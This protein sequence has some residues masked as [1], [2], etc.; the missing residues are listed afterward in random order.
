MTSPQPAYDASLTR[1]AVEDLT[2][3]YD[4]QQ[5]RVISVREYAIRRLRGERFPTQTLWPLRGVSFD[6][7]AGESFGIVGRNGAGKSTL[8]KVIAGIV[9]PT[10]GRVRVHGHLSPL[11]ELGAGFDHEL[12]GRE[13]IQ[14]YGTLL[15]LR[16]KH[17]RDRVAAIADFAELTPFIDVP[18]K[19]YSSGMV[20]RLA[21]AIATD[22]DPDILIVDEVLSVGDAPFQRKCEERLARF[23][24]RGVTVLLV[25]HDLHLLTETCSR[26]VLLEAGASCIVGAAEEIAARYA[27]R[28]GG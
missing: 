8:L 7:R 21:F 16:R 1:V 23:R 5:E 10:R 11:L 20:A 13:N 27:E 2:V 14:L 26:A 15:G 19:N 4:L 17:L 22:S 25:T 9:P 28:T 3:R 6:V 18:L 24:A 12:T